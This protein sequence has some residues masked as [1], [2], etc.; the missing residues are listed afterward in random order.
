[1]NGRSFFPEN[2]ALEDFIGETVNYASSALENDSL[3]PGKY[4]VIVHPVALSSF[5]EALVM[6]MDGRQVFEGLSPLK[7]RMGDRICSPMISIAD[8]PAPPELVPYFHV[9]DEGLPVMRRP[10]IQNG[11][12]KSFLTD[13]EY[14]GRLGIPSTGHGQ[15][16]ETFTYGG[17]IGVEP[18]ISPTNLVV[19]NGEMPVAEMI[20]SI[21]SGLLLIQ[22]WDVWSGTLIN[23]D[24]SGTVSLGFRIHNGEV[25]GRVKD[26]RVSGNIYDFLGKQLAGISLERPATL[27]GDL[28]AP[29]LLINDVSVA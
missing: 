21:Q 3:S 26:M 23:G 19:E 16:L 4:P 20:R 1:M 29:Y 7:H 24:V 14:A 15:R 25:K 5:F 9:S 13:L 18:H 2:T 6:A 28:L 10:L 12:L 11:E 8:D 27:C 22:T 17:E